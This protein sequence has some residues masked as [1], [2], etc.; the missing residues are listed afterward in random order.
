MF[1]KQEKVQQVQEI[2][3]S[4]NTIGKGTTITGD[5]ETFGNL[6][7]DGKVVGN[8]KTKSKI[9]LGNTGYVEGNI[10]AQNAELE[11]EV[12]GVVEVSELLVLKPTSVINGDIVT[13]KLVVES[14]AT[15]NGDCK[16]GVSNKQ[17]KIGGE[18]DAKNGRLNLAESKEKDKESKS[19]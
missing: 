13:N 9:V 5:I 14:G 15:F 19:V 12:K 7:M 4:S 3:N 2:T 17:I 1:G 10:L 8:I 16:M 18:E 11:G 6:R